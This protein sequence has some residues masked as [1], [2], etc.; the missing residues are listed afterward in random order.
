MDFFKPVAEI[1]NS[2]R[3]LR[4]LEKLTDEQEILEAMGSS[5]GSVKLECVKRL[6]DPDKLATA[7][8][9]KYD[10]NSAIA[11][12]EKITDDSALARVAVNHPAY[13]HDGIDRS[14][15]KR[16]RDPEVLHRVFWGCQSSDK[17]HVR[18]IVAKNL[19][20]QNHPVNSKY[21]E[22]IA[23]NGTD[24]G[25]A[26][27][28]LD[29]ITDDSILSR[30]VRQNGNPRVQL[31]AAKKMQDK[32]RAKESSHAIG[33]NLRKYFHSSTRRSSKRSWRDGRSISDLLPIHVC[34]FIG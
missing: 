33:R 19:L 5:I 9:D 20:D 14:A 1:R 8:L 7:I 13:H 16:I 15:A 32:E 18:I 11:A 4:K 3:A 29:N 2:K 21:Y 12:L 27:R 34:K 31:A 22:D 28:A 26:L 17:V 24:E 6:S 23:R 30:V 10:R 25:D